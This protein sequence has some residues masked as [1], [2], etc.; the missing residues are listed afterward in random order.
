LAQT[1]RSS[2][3]KKSAG[4]ILAEI[5]RIWP[6]I[7]AVIYL[8]GFFIIVVVYLVGM[9]LSASGSQSAFPSLQPFAHVFAMPQFTEALANTA[10]FVII[11]TPLEL[12]IGLW[13]ALILYQPFRLRGFM[14]SI[15]MIPIAVPA[16]VSATLLFILFDFPGGHINHL[17]MGGYSWFPQIM[18]S[19]VNWRSSKVFALSISMAGKVWRDMPISM[20]ILLAGLNSIDPDLFDAAKTMGAGLRKR[21]R[22]IILPL[23]IPSI[24]AVLLLRSI[25]MWK[26]FIFPFVL[27]GRYNLLGTLIESLYNDWGMSKESAA[28]ALILVVCTA[29]TAALLGGL[30]E[31]MSKRFGRQGSRGWP[32]T[33]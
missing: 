31:L 7:P 21:L 10:L 19:P 28:V 15:V 11:G 33:A 18:D 32:E 17:L 30:L 12:V 20:L 5:R 4:N 6:L 9:S 14:R 2:N 16:L 29:G 23:I 26:E 3:V 27:A 24:S 13:L 25:E 8:L 22:Y 1:I